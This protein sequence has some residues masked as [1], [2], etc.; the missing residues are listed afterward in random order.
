MTVGVRLVGQVALIEKAGHFRSLMPTTKVSKSTGA[1][2]MLLSLTPP[3]PPL[4]LSN[5]GLFLDLIEMLSP[6]GVVLPSQLLSSP[7]VSLQRQRR[8]ERERRRGKGRK[9]RNRQR[10]FYDQL[11]IWMSGCSKN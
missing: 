5:P 8:E 4:P 6:R 9:R 1:V 7:H 2:N 3:P 10:N 11:S